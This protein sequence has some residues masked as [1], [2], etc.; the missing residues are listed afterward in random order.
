MKR[1]QGLIRPPL[2]QSLPSPQGLVL[3]LLG[4]LP[5]FLALWLLAGWGSCALA[6]PVGLA[7]PAQ[8]GWKVHE[9]AVLRDVSPQVQLE[10]VIN[11]QAGAFAPM[12]S[13]L[14]HSNEWY[15][16]T[17]L[18]IHLVTDD[19]AQTSTP[20]PSANDPL[21]LLDLTKPYIDEVRL[22]TPADS[23]SP[24]SNPDK[25][26]GT[27]WN[28]QRVGDT[29]A[30]D[31]WIAQIKGLT[32]RFA[33]PSA[34]QVR[35]AGAQGL[36]LYMQIS[37]LVPLHLSPQWD[38]LLDA[39]QHDALLLAIYGLCLGAILMAILG[40]T[41]SLLQ[42]R[43]SLY[44]W[45]ALYAVLT[46]LAIIGHSGLGHMLL[47]PIEGRWPSTAVPFF[48]AL[49][50]ITQLYFC[51]NILSR[52]KE[53]PARSW[54]MRIMVGA[55]VLLN[56]C[57]VFLPG[58]WH[59][60]Y[61]CFLGIFAL[62]VLLCLIWCFEA[63]QRKQT[64]AKAW[65]AAS[66]PLYVVTFW[67]VLDGIGLM[68]A[69]AWSHVAVIVAAALDAIIMGLVLQWFARQRYA[70]KERERALATRDPLTGFATAEVFKSRL[71][72]AWKY[73]Q[74][75]GHDVAVA[76]VQ[77]MATGDNALRAELML[78]RSVRVLRAATRT[79]DIVG[80]LEGRLLAVLLP[81]MSL[82][83]DLAQRLA[84][85]IAQGLMPDQ[86]DPRTTVLQFRI[87]ATSFKHYGRDSE[88]L[89]ADLRA[90]LARPSGWGSKPI[91]YIDHLA[92]Q[93]AAAA[94]DSSALEDVWSKALA[95]EQKSD[96]PSRPAPLQSTGARAATTAPSPL[97]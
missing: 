39:Q 38:T 48:V 20:S 47:W 67:A 68:P 9:L 54:L 73:H 4:W 63:A 89:D 5:I 8:T 42:Q 53:L 36:V 71:Q 15:R 78:S 37:G 93:E 59:I 34:Q 19:S 69:G 6:M 2:K 74:A 21:V 81:E 46:M 66:T 51:R 10:Q 12:S 83:D 92:A 70:A 30:R 60:W 18:R 80:R 23:A 56:G 90:L 52:T 27:R 41:L 88:R 79:H 43:D 76:Y 50:C 94:V 77:L 24:D 86:T 91:R 26:E 29:V 14:I 45:Y 35:A 7:L 49:A 3:S 22:Y 62:T 58:M 57:F 31:Q 84:R 97:K 40:A 44:G 85:I 96:K 72:R 1:I 87:A 33:M 11:G 28:M 32:P 61:F 75:G 95:A 65:F 64:L 25:S 16:S 17:W 13:N 82:G 55:I